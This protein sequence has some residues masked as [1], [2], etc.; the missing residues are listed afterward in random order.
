MFNPLNILSDAKLKLLTVVCVS[1][2]LYRFQGSVPLKCCA[3]E[4]ACT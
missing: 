4:R 3:L 1:F 2:I